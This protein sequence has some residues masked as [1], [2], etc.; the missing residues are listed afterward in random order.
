[1][2]IAYFAAN[3]SLLVAW[4]W[5]IGLLDAQVDDVARWL[6]D[7]DALDDVRWWRGQASGDA[8]NASWGAGRHGD[9]LASEHGSLVLD[10]RVH[11]LI[12]LLEEL[13]IVEI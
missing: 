6:H 7:R 1:M 2:H 8:G 5:L 12:D 9:H 3:V 4:S 11:D 13:W 10:Q